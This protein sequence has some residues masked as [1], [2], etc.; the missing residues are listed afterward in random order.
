MASLNSNET[1]PKTAS[2]IHNFFILLYLPQL[3]WVSTI[4]FLLGSPLEKSLEENYPIPRTH[5]QNN[6]C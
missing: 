2:L 5:N 3:A 4:Y 6:L 1:L